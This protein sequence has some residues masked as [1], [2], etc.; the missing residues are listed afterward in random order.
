MSTLVVTDP[1]DII[2]YHRHPEKFHQRRDE[3]LQRAEQR[4]E[5][6][7]GLEEKPDFLFCGASGSLVFQ[8]PQMF[9]E[10]ALPVLKRVTEMAYD[11]GIPT[12]IHS[13]GPERL[14]VK[15]AVE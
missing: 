5:V 3:M 10:L 15:M 11:L 1:D 2:E 9:R 14:L 13:C 7:A 6:I 12:H 8:S 4:M